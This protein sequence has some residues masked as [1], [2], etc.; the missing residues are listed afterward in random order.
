[1]CGEPELLPDGFDNLLNPAVLLEVLSDGTEDYDRGH[2]CRPRKF[3]RYRSIPTFQEYVLID[4]Q[5]IVAE[6]WRKN[7]RGQWTLAEQTT[8]SAGQF[9]IETISLTISL[10]TV[11]NRT[12]DLLPFSRSVSSQTGDTITSPT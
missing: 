8:D 1:M 10:E 2:S 3:V 4:S 7:E 5:T 9:T 11:Y 12:T 6:V